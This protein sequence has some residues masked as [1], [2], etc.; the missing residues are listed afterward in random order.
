MKHAHTPFR[1]AY[2][3]VVLSEYAMGVL[4]VCAYSLEQRRKWVTDVHAT[5]PF[6]L[7]EG[8][9]G[10]RSNQCSDFV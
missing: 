7:F 5:A 1:V 9:E 10:F 2:S 8:F 6:A 3:T 4:F